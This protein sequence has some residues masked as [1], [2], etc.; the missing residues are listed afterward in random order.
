VIKIKKGTIKKKKKKK[1]E[2][3]TVQM[4]SVSFVNV[5]KKARTSAMK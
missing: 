4:G 3:G 5:S 2:M 1:K